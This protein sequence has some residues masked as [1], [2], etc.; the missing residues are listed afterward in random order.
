M[1]ISVPMSS[2]LSAQPPG[3]FKNRRRWL[4]AFGAVQILIACF[5]LLIVAY[6][7]VEFVASMLP[8]RPAGAPEPGPADLVAFLI[9]G[10]LAVPFLILGVGSIKCKNWA[11]IASQIVSGLWLFIGVVLSL[12]LIFALPRVMEPH[13]QLQRGQL[14]L[15]TM[16]TGFTMV[17]MPATLLV[18][19]SL[20]SV[21]A[22]CRAS[23]LVQT[24]TMATPEQAAG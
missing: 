19:Y 10:G 24:S 3:H 15:V 5:F 11:R 21:R 16:V 14:R 2:D 6:T 18:F 12:I 22:T 13:D 9:C 7:M 4:I 8:N 17:V 23:G 20:K 1:E